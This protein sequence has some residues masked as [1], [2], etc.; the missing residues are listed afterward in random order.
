MLA[1]LSP[2]DGDVGWSSDLISALS[3]IGVLDAA[4]TTLTSD[5]G[6]IDAA[7]T[8]LSAEVVAA[9]GGRADLATRLLANIRA[10]IVNAGVYDVGHYVDAAWN[11]SAAGTIAG[12]AAR[13]EVVRF[14]VA[15][16]LRV[17][18]MGFEVTVGVASAEIKLV[19]YASDADG[20]P[21]ELLYE[22]APMSA[23]SPAFV[24]VADSF[25]FEA[26]TLYWV[27]VRHSSTATIRG[28]ALASMPSIGRT[29]AAGSTYPGILRQS[30][31][32]ATPAP[33]P[34]GYAAS[35]VTVNVVGPSAR[36]LI[37]ELF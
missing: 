7:L 3:Q 17:N 26:N 31:A 15:R 30:V 14:Q 22:S 2:A 8:A 1:K 18:P 35:Q 13:M 34:F 23:A 28:I 25:T 10:P 9:R 29:A 21:A 11:A 16:R 37:A 32:F 36:M 27:G 4:L 6:V 12:S 5:V 19:I 20:H 24:S 33:N